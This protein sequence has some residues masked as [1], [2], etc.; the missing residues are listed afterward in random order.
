MIYSY[1]CSHC[2]WDCEYEY[3]LTNSEYK[4]AECPQCGSELSEELFDDENYI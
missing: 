2:A 4:I 1:F 3:P